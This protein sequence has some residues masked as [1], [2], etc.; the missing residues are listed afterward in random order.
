MGESIIGII[1]YI[2]I[3]RIILGIPTPNSPEAP[4]SNLALSKPGGP[5]TTETERSHYPLSG[6]LDLDNIFYLF[7]KSYNPT[8]TLRL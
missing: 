4:G 1:V 5:C 2:Y 6:T 8:V 7:H 3:F